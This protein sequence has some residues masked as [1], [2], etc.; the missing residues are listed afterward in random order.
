MLFGDVLHLFAAY[1]MARLVGG[2][3]G[4]NVAGVAITLVLMGWRIYFLALHYQYDV[5]GAGQPWTWS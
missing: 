4:P 1:S 3:A 5:D 2:W